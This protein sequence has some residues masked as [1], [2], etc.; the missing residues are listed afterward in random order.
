[1]FFCVWFLIIF[2]QSRHLVGHPLLMCVVVENYSASSHMFSLGRHGNLP[3]PAQG[4]WREML[5]PCLAAY[6]FSHFFAIFLQQLS[7]LRYDLAHFKRKTA[8]RKVYASKCF[9][10]VWQGGALAHS[11]RVA[12]SLFFLLLFVT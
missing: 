2:Y 3:L 7:V 1:M 11:E 5:V 10:I 6:N 8:E 4:K 12:A 9:F